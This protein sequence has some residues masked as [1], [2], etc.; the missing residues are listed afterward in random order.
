MSPF[1]TMP[2]M[3]ASNVRSTALAALAASALAG[4]VGYG[5]GDLQPGATEA[6][7]KARMGEPRERQALPG[8]GARL[9]YARGPYGKHTWRIELDGAGRVIGV[10]Q[11]LTE[12]NF[13][14]LP[15]EVPAAEVR[16]RLGPPSEQ[17]VG[18]RGVGEVWSYRY[19]W[20]NYC[21]WFQV[22]LVDGRVREA[23]YA[24]DPSCEEKL[25]D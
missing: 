1:T 21:R 14:A 16:N 2:P 13:E 22:W 19:E 23:G 15:L 7:V 11:L 12:S 24:I 4:C 18:W 3:R 25:P 6:Q 8:G 5:P 10:R 17:R 20:L 9:D